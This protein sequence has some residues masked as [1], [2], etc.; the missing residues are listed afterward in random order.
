MEILGLYAVA[1]FILLLAWVW[2]ALK[3]APTPR[4]FDWERFMEDL[5]AE[6]KWF[7]CIEG[8][9]CEWPEH[10]RPGDCRKPE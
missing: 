3:H 8:P 2:E 1:F 9:G 5:E 10:C 4:H 6:R 7:H